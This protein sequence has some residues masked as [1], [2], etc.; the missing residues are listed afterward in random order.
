MRHAG[1]PLHQRVGHIALKSI[2]HALAAGSLVSKDG[3]RTQPL[4]FSFVTQPTKRYLP[5]RFVGIEEE[6]WSNWSE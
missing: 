5:L 4:L 2:R 6:D 1:C 3:G